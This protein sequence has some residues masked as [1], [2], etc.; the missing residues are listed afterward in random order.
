MQ[1]RTTDGSIVPL[2]EPK[3]QPLVLSEPTHSSKC[4]QTNLPLFSL[5]YNHTLPGPLP[6]S[7]AIY[8]GDNDK[9]FIS[10]VLL[11]DDIVITDAHL[12]VVPGSAWNDS[13][14]VRTVDPAEV[15]VMWV[16]H[17]G[18][19]YGSQVVT[20]H[21]RERDRGAYQTSRTFD[22]A[23]L[24]LKKPFPNSGA[25][26]W[27][28]NLPTLERYQLGVTDAWDV[29]ILDFQSDVLATPYV[30]LINDHC[31][32]KNTPIPRVKMSMEKY[33][34]GPVRVAVKTGTGFLIR[35]GDSWFVH[36]ILSTTVASGDDRWV[37]TDLAEEG[38]SSWLR[39]K[40]AEESVDPTLHPEAPAEPARRS[41][42]G[43]T[44]IPLSS[45]ADNGTLAD[46]MP[47]TVVVYRKDP[48][49][50]IRMSPG[51]LVRVDAVLT[52]ASLLVEPSG[53]GSDVMRAVD[54]ESAFVV[55]FTPSG[56]R[57]RSNVLKIFV[58]EKSHRLGSS[59]ATFNLALLRLGSPFL[60]SSVACLDLENTLPGLL[61]GKMGVMETWNGDPFWFSNN[62]VATTFVSNADCMLVQK[63]A[64]VTS[65]MLCTK[66][67]RALEST[68]KPRKG[69]K[70][71]L[72]VKPGT[73]FF[74]RSG[75]AWFVRGIVAFS[76]GSGEDRLAVVALAD[77][78]TR[79][80]LR[81]K[82]SV[83]DDAAHL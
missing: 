26:C 49:G 6:W 14:A 24:R 52:D 43:K 12:L 19:R 27:D 1:L 59:N 28:H 71:L 64:N 23:L 74:E 78:S 32:F 42:C 2:P 44:T 22:V 17:T 61:E 5:A 21:A 65:D 35:K 66:G 55:W 54:P 68:L 25:A 80:W 30:N 36:G 34:T 51:V 82:M 73:G 75:D 11:R 37:I 33:C 50:T 7:V 62:I 3:L 20:V 63:S 31:I 9:T 67:T 46:H 60:N 38:V 76:G 16:S 45:L 69:V 79:A 81:E 53:E 48:N 58:G 10:G 47:W 15:R 57:R 83:G 18:R 77:S 13:V 8:I 72:D 56:R 41:E 39:E 70:V 29:S 40:L 4:G